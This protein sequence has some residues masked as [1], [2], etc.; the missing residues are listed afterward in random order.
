LRAVGNFPFNFSFEQIL[1]K[2]LAT[3][4][5][6]DSLFQFFFSPIVLSQA[7]KEKGNFLMKSTAGAESKSHRLPS[8]SLKAS[9][10]PMLA[11]GGTEALDNPPVGSQ[12]YP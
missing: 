5:I 7:L 8:L 2:D 10:L 3:M 1:R 9:H 4:A 6:N 11:P 12:G